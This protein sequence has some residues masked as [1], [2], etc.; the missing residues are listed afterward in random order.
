[1]L[2]WLLFLLEAISYLNVV[3]TSQEHSGVT[4]LRISASLP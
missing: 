2:W 1:M 3:L 4:E